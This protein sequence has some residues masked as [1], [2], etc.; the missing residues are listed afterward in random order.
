MQPEYLQGAF[1]VLT[2]IFGWIWMRTKV[3]KIVGIVW[4][5]FCTCRR[6]YEDSYGRQ[7]TREGLTYHPLLLQR[8]CCP[9]WAMDLAEVSL[10][11]HR[12]IHHA[13][14]HGYQ[15]DATASPPRIPK[16]ILSSS[17]RHLGRWNDQSK[18]ARAGQLD[19][20]TSMFTSCTAKCEIL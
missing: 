7:I 5:S 20:W 16:R 14:I 1:N 17:Q 11:Y 10:V 13:V 12:H 15:C 4:H 18:C 9:E 2:G 6:H 8:V 19:K 3:G